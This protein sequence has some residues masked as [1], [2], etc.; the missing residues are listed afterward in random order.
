MTTVKTVFVFL[1]LPSFCNWTENPNS[2]CIDLSYLKAGSLQE[3]AT[4]FIR[5]YGA[6]DIIQ[7]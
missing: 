5:P 1:E 6:N 4:V 2:E 3:D 7:G